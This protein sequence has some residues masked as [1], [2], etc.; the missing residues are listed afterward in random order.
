MN[1]AKPLSKTIFVLSVL[2][3]ISIG[4]TSCSKDEPLDEIIPSEDSQDTPSEGEDM[5][6]MKISIKI[7]SASF[8]A[9]LDNTATG[10]AFQALLPMTVKMDELGGNEKYYYLSSNLPTATY[11]PGTIHEGD[12]MLYGS[13]CVVLFYKTFSS[14]YSY[15]RIGKIDN[16]QGLA[17][18]VG[19]RD[20][21]ITFENITKNK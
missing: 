20:I 15:T 8:S 14:S 6:N 19:S 10:Q 17:T 16:P 5:T 13:S 3:F 21:S 12:L 7:G 18:A 1:W 2:C 11:S 9:T 4:I